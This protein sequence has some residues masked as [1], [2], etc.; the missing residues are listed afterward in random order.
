MKKS[1]LDEVDKYR[2][3]TYK[4][5]FIKWFQENAPT[6]SL[7][8]VRLYARNVALVS[9][10]LFPKS[11]R[12]IDIGMFLEKLKSK[13][14]ENEVE[15]KAIEIDTNLNNNNTIIN[16]VGKVIQIASKI[17]EIP[18][19]LFIIEQ[20]IRKRSALLR[21][22]I[23]A[24]KSKNIKSEDEEA[25]MKPF[26]EYVKVAEDIYEDY[27]K[28]MD[29]A[30]KSDNFEEGV[31]TYLPKL[32]FRNAVLI[33]LILLN[34]TTRGGVPLYSILRLV[35]YT[36]LYLWNKKEKPKLKGKRNYISIEDR[37]I[38]LQSNKTTGGLAANDKQQP[39][40]KLFK[41]YNKK[42][43]DMIKLYSEVY[44]I[45]NDSPLFT[46]TTARGGET[47][48]NKT[49]LSKLLRVQFKGIADHTT[50]GLIRK[51]YD[52][53]NVDMNFKQ[54]KESA[55]LNDHNIQTIQTFYK[56]I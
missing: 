40:L 34:R 7:N 56:K 46:S 38:Y 12:K 15:I 14:K 10:N 55:K 25:N 39:S 28:N 16:A 37:V 36:D 26:N 53:R 47:S 32:K 35:E 23:F 50:I 43:I 51:A 5:Y 8:S 44:D 9:I 6:L 21:E 29:L 41:I 24:E 45:K 48:L 18:D 20:H 52:N 22:E 1:D 17:M 49:A 4:A 3:E 42:I 33:S 30:K 27:V 19:T 13:Y 54:Y 2:F 31:K 11:N